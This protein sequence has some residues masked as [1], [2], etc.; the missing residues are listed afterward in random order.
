MLKRIKGTPAPQGV[1]LPI[2]EA[3]FPS[4]FYDGLQYS[5][6]ARGTWNIVH[7]NMLSLIHI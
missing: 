7:T 2:A 5:P 3:K 1:Y 4:F 6:P